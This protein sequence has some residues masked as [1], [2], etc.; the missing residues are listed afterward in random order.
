MKFVEGKTGETPKRN[1]PDSVRSSRNPHGVTETRTVYFIQ[2]CDGASGLVGRHSCY[3]QT[4]KYRGFT[5]THHS[6]R[7]Y[8][9]H[10]LRNYYFITSPI[11]WSFFPANTEIIVEP[12]FLENHTYRCHVVLLMGIYLCHIYHNT[13]FELLDRYF[14]GCCRSHMIENVAGRILWWHYSWFLYHIF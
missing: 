10:E 6:T 3:S 1:Y 13:I 12:P 8:V 14:S 9:G 4:L 11:S 2:P 5:A 7:S